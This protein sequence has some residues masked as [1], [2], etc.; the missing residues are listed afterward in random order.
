VITLL[1]GDADLNLVVNSTDMSIVG[2]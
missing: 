2:G 1:A